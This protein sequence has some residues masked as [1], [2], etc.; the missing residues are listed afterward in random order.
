MALV[1]HACRGKE[2]PD[3]P[4]SGLAGLLLTRSIPDIRALMSHRG[5]RAVPEADILKT[6]MRR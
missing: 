6:V 1:L 5:M 3:P 4:K 2:A